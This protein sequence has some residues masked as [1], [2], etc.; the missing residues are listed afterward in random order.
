MEGIPGSPAPDGTDVR[1]RGRVRLVSDRTRG[2]QVRVDLVGRRSRST[3]R[4]RSQGRHEHANGNSTGLAH[5]KA[6][7]D[8]LYGQKWPHP[9]VRLTQALRPRKPH[10]SRLFEAD[11]A[12][13]RDSI[14]ST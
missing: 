13:V 2:G 6:S 8:P 7:G 9:D 1:S 12:R 11:Y 5:P 4:A 10:L 14:R 3:A